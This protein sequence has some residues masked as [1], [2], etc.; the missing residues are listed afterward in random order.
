M[1]DLSGIFEARGRVAFDDGVHGGVGHAVRGTNY[2]F[3]DFVA[4]NFALMVNLH[5]AAEHQT[6]DLRAQAAN[7]G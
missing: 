6:I 1:F 2:A 3:I 4:C 5:G 7:V